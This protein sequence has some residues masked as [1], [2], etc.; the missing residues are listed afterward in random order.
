VIVD[1]TFSKERWRAAATALAASHDADLHEICC[2]LPADVAAD[3]LAH[4]TVETDDP[5]D[6]TAAIAARMAD[7]SDA[8]PSADAIDTSTPLTD[9]IPTVLGRLG[10]DRR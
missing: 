5:S 2:V 10:F 9:V 6:A 3:R 7:Q 8:W 4:R 1:G